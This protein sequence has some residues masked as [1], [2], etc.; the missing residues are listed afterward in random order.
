[1]PVTPTQSIHEYYPSAFVSF[2]SGLPYPAC[3]CPLVYRTT[4]LYPH[5]PPAPSCTV[6]RRCMRLLSAPERGHRITFPLLPSPATPQKLHYRT[7]RRDLGI[8][9]LTPA[10]YSKAGP[11]PARSPLCP[12]LITCCPVC[13]GTPE[14]GARCVGSAAHPFLGDAFAQTTARPRCM[15]CSSTTPARHMTGLRIEHVLDVLVQL[16]DVAA[17]EKT[18]ASISDR[19]RR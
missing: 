2:A 17:E 3:I 1:M 10:P 11:P 12:Q 13:E 8:L 18:R 6:P 5:L 19:R 16:L 9:Q 7:V 15:A 4:S 14:V